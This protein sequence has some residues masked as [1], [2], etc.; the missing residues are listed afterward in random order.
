MP[1]DNFKIIYHFSLLYDIVLFGKIN[2]E[3]FI[4]VITKCPNKFK[5]TRNY[6][7]P[8]CIYVQHDNKFCYCIQVSVLSD[9]NT[10]NKPLK[11]WFFT[12]IKKHSPNIHENLLNNSSEII[13]KSKNNKFLYG[14]YDIPS[15]IWCIFVGMLTAEL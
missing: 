1:Y 4:C 12:L 15:Y 13:I 8:S 10:L 3:Y 5:K 7:S 11:E 2:D 14:V 6:Q 9:K